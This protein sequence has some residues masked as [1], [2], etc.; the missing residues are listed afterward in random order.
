[1]RAAIVIVPRQRIRGHG[2]RRRIFR[3][4]QDSA[5]GL[6]PSLLSNPAASDPKTEQRRTLIGRSFLGH[7]GLAQAVPEPLGKGKIFWVARY[8]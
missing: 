3:F 7:P 4:L 8:G 2:G 6:A 1:M 5:G